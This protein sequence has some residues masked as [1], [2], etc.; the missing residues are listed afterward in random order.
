MNPRFGWTLFGPVENAPCSETHSVNLAA[1]RVLRIATHRDEMDMHE[2]E[3]T[4]NSVPSGNW[5]QL[6]LSVKKTLF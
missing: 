4:R 1:T 6:E 2:V 3:L 5:N